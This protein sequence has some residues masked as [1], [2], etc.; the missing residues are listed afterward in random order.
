M[1]T[2][3]MLTVSEVA[4][5]MKSSAQMVRVMLQ[6]GNCPFGYAVKGSGSRFKYFIFKER[7]L[8]Y[9]KGN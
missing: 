4:E 9:V 3:E 5:A 1:L 8:N 7:F 6:K 2:V